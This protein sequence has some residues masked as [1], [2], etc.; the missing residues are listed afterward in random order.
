MG[1]DF[2]RVFTIPTDEVYARLEAEAQRR[3]FLEPIYAAQLSDRFAHRDENREC[4]L[5][6]GVK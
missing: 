2:K 1:I 4:F 3:C 5:L 6:G